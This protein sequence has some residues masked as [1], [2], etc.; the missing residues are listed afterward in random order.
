[1]Q[2]IDCNLPCSN[3]CPA[4]DAL[5]RWRGRLTVGH[6][7]DRNISRRLS[8]N[9]SRRNMSSAIQVAHPARADPP[10]F[11]RTGPHYRSPCLSRKYCYSTCPF[12]IACSAALMRWR[13][14][15]RQHANMTA[16][17]LSIRQTTHAHTAFRRR[18]LCR[19]I[20]VRV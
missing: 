8:M 7:P 17:S 12:Q 18:S 1:M 11:R 9:I 10:I 2:P 5:G 19:D 6:P 15:A 4:N 13:P 3:C 14:L 16:L 20:G